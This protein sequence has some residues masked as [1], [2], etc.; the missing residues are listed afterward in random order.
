MNFDVKPIFNS[1]KFAWSIKS[2][3]IIGLSKL[4]KIKQIKS[5]F[6]GQAQGIKIYDFIMKMRGGAA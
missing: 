5:H 6:Y 2:E 3:K 1:D 4:R